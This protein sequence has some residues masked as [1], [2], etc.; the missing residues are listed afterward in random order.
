MP[1]AVPFA[2]SR[3]VPQ[4]AVGDG[5]AFEVFKRRLAV[6]PADSEE[7]LDRVFRLRF[8]V[9]C[10]ERGFE[11]P[12]GH[13]DGRERDSDDR[14]AL[15]F[16]VLDRATG[17]AAGTVR[18]ILPQPGSDLPVFK[19][20][21]AC[22]PAV[23]LPQRSTAEVSR[24]AI[25]K[26]F[27]RPL[28]ASWCRGDGG[29]T[30]LPIITFGLIQAIVMM[31]SIGGITHIVAMMEPALLRLLRRMGIEFHPVGGLVEHHGWRQPGWAAMAGLA[32]R[33]KECHRELWDIATDAGQRLPAAPPLA[34]A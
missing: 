12:A 21:A 26:A 18:L 16:L 2:S 3:E 10:V 23:G 25:A 6:V 11:D 17:E 22:Q 5:G 13:P 20:S 31:S 24:F 15:H 28:E 8:Q 9:Y 30:A 34:F 1:S 14:R 27:R 4:S 33:V 7:L 19:L 29:R 32:E